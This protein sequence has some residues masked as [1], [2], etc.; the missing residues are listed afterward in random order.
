VRNRDAAE[1]VDL[2]GEAGA[3]V[4]VAA[5]GSGIQRASGEVVGFLHAD[6]LYARDD[7]IATIAAAFADPSVEAIYGDLIY[8]DRSDT[9]KVIRYWRAGTCSRERL[10]R[11]WMPPHPTF[12]VR[13]AVYERLGMFDTR[14]RIAAD[15]DCVVRFLFVAGIH[16]VYI[17]QV[18]VSMRLGGISNRSVR[19]ILRKS[20]E[21]LHIM[22]KHRLGHLPALL[23]KNL[24]KVSQFW[25]R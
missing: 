4:G 3:F 18:L 15:Y 2:G 23:H 10:S 22:R 5:T 9:S 8:V 17:P 6:D 12:Y 14:Y 1:A 21:D 16:A 7:T 11:G 13:R 19:T 24:G 25:T 20:R